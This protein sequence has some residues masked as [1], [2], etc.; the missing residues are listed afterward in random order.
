LGQVLARLAASGVRDIGASARLRARL[1]AEPL[2]IAD[3]IL[4]EAVTPDMTAVLLPQLDAG[5]VG[6]RAMHATHDRLRSSV[7][8]DV[9]GYPRADVLTSK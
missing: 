8:A 9:N 2:A 1:A 7:V 4:D 6:Q 5:A 3:A